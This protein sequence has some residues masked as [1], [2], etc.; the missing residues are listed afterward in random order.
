[1]F[2]VALSPLLASLIDAISLLQSS[3]VADCLLSSLIAVVLVADLVFL[4]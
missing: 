2:L 4:S 1:M 3:L